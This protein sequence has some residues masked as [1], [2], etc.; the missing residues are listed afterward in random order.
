MSDRVIH[1]ELPLDSD[2]FLRRACPFCRREFKAETSIQDRQSWVQH[3]LEAYLL[4]Q[5]MEIEESQH[6]EQEQNTR[7]CPYCG[8]QAYADSWWTQ[9][10]IA[11]VNTFAHNIM[12]EMVN[13]MLES[14]KRQFPKSS[15]GLI[16]F[17]FKYEAMS[18]ITPWI[19]PEVDDMETFALPCCNLRIKL[20]DNW[21]RMAYCHVCGFPHQ[22][23]GKQS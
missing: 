3:Q 5:G 1:I 12:A 9:E 10:Q 18:Y 21:S 14:L 6:S 23:L 20:E 22:P 19:S 15:T 16:S 11:Y 17:E 2:N 4:Q 7:W 13:E 8:E